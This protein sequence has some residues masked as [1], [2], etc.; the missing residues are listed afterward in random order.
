MRNRETVV[1][2]DRIKLCHDL[3]YPGSVKRIRNKTFD[4]SD[5][6]SKSYECSLNAA[7][8]SDDIVSDV[9]N[10]FNARDSDASSKC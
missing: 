5:K 6:V 4:E 10:L 8:E 3:D 2:H 1:H 7:L 9:V